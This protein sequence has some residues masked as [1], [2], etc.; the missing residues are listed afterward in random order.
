MEPKHKKS[1]PDPSLHGG[2]VQI[3]L[4]GISRELAAAIHQIAA[5]E[6]IALD[7][8]ALKLL[9]RGAGIQQNPDPST[10]IGS[11]LDHLFGVWKPDDA[12]T[13]LASI[14]HCERIDQDFW[15]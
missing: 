14:R 5:S 2:F 10:T 1:L 12:E 4:R 3:T 8:A 6:G 11:D 7:E 13:F 15:K 9:F